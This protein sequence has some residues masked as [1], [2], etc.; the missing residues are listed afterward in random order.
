LR[1]EVKQGV[2]FAEFIKFAAS[3]RVFRNETEEEH[4]FD[5][6]NIAPSL[7]CVQIIW[8]LFVLFPKLFEKSHKRV[9]L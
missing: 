3:V 4:I 1:I 6:A 5:C 7:L 9:Y 2:E 8:S